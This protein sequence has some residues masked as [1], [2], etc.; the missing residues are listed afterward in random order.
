MD[1][2]FKHAARE[3]KVALFL[4]AAAM[5]WILGYAAWR[6]YGRPA[7]DVAFIWGIPDWIFWAVVVPWFACLGASIWFGLRFMKDDDLGPEARDVE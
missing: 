7:E 3:A 5:A 1:A 2:V 4:C 6:G